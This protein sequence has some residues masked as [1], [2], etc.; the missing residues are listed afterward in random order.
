MLRTHTCGELRKEMGNQTVTLCG[1]V[2]ARRDHGKLIFIDVRDRYGLTQVVFVPS[3]SKTA[4]DTAQKLGPEF[5]VKVT[6]KVAVRPPKMVNPDLPTGEIEVCA[7]QLEILNSSLVPAFEIDDKVEVSEEV[8]LAYRYLDLRRPKVA[9]ILQTRHKLCSVIRSFLYEENFLEVETPVLTKSTPEGARDFLVPARLNPGKFYALP[10]SP[11][12]FK[13]MLMV[14]GFDRYFQIVKCFRDEDLR[15]D[16]Q[17]E[18]TQLDMEMSFVEEEDIFALTERLYQKIF[19]EIKGIDLPIPFPRM[20][21]AEAMAKYKSDKP[22][23]R[24]PGQ[25]F[26]F[27]WVVDFPMFHYNEEE[28]RWESEHHPF[29]SIR[30][31]FLPLLEQGEYAR[32]TARSYDLVLNGSEI[33]SGSIR[34]HKKDMQKKIFDIIGLNAQEAQ[35]RFGFL[36][37]AFEYGAPPHAGVAYGIDRLTMLLTGA[38]SIRD[39]IAFPKTQKGSCL[40]TDAPSDVDEKQ[41]LELGVMAIKRSE[42]Q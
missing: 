7:E 29:T 23:I 21:H 18:F 22:D 36:L 8:K 9:K 27:L 34:I 32:I 25:E 16:R 24:Q 38:E 42:D 33:G 5:V 26:A 30:E 10:Q 35:Q 19:K 39:T 17:P 14:S 13:Q 31:E 3:V 41:L 37:K 4:H 1:W 11:Q 15:A 28:K 6:G 2:A 40:V 12:L 20:T